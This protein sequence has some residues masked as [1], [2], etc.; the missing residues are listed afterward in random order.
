M[1]Q[2]TVPGAP[3]VYYGDEVGL[4]GAD[5]PDDRR[6]FPWVGDNPG[7]DA[8]IRAF[9][10]QLAT[11]RRNNSVLRNGALKFLLTDDT[12]RTL[13]YAMRT[14]TQVAVVAINR[15]ET[16]PRTLTI[17]VAG[18]LRNGVTFTNALGGG[19]AQSA[20]GNIVVT[21]PALG[22]GIWIANGGQDLTP[23]AAPTGLVAN[24]GNHQVSL[25]WSVAPGATSYRVYRSP[26]SGGGYTF[27]GGTS[28]TSL[29][30]TGA[31]NASL[32]YYVVTALDAVGNESGW[33][34]EANA[35]P[36]APIGW[37]GHLWPPSL[38]ITINAL[39]SQRV[40]AQV[41]VDGV[42][43]QPGQ[44]PGVSAEFAF[45]PA[46]SDPAGWAWA[47]MTY[48]TDVGNNDEY[49]IDF[50]PEQTGTFQYLARFS[51]DLRR[52]W[53]YAYT[54]DNQRGS[55]V[56]NPSSDTTAPAAPGNL[57]RVNSSAGS[58]TVGWDANGEPDLYRYEVWRGSASGGPY[59]K[60]ANVPAGT[61][62]YVD[63]EVTTGATYY[64]VVTA[65]DTSFNR[66]ANSNEA[67]AQAQAQMVAV[68]FT[69]TVPGTT[70][71]G[72]TVHIAGSFPAP[73]PQWDPG[74]LPLTWVDAQHARITLNMLE[75][76]QVEYKYTLG[77]WD[78]VE[79]GPACEELNNRQL[80][81]VY[82][83]GGAQAVNDTVANWR[84]V[85]PCGN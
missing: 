49:R 62:Q 57:H 24:A 43:N 14:A 56:V 69:V 25:T 79:K 28:G 8:A 20:G 50:T 4:T 36:S 77:D 58:I 61:T 3:T 72:S 59:A 75:G 81:V 11:I 53:T 33:S 19:G 52:H 83:P 6:T 37:A 13:A 27:V 78:H 45:G 55:L 2:F 29:T 44:G 66:S 1:V 63:Q 40:Y 60:V 68:T 51:T 84:N 48:N 22:A 17:P 23:P 73:Y 21:L 65:Q 70:P 71:P 32:Y 34:N 76:T 18:Y 7:G 42:T 15:N 85:S 41:W 10:S 54:D 67:S 12:N 30:D 9:Y 80:T 74:A 16:G 46:G 31:S 39:Q 26:L 47:P 5:D 35:V 38:T 82:G 64:Y